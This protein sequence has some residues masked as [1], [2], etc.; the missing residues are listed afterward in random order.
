MY[1]L[2]PINPMVI[3]DISHESHHNCCNR[4]ELRCC[5]RWN[6]FLK[7][8]GAAEPP[9]VSFSRTSYAAIAWKKAQK[10]SRAP[11]VVG[12]KLGF[13]WVL[14]NSMVRQQTS[15]SNGNSV[16]WFPSILNGLSLFVHMSPV[17]TAIPIFKQTMTDPKNCRHSPRSVRLV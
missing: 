13:R 4:I 6:T 15:L 14:S 5:E 12:K 16:G 7:M 9:I 2:N 17:K 8:E 10:A 3:Y 1:L 11:C